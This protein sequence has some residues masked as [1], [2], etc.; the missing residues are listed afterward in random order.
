[1]TQ[2]ANIHSDR[3]L[4]CCTRYSRSCICLY[5]NSIPKAIPDY[6]HHRRSYHHRTLSCLR[7]R[8]HM[9]RV[10][11]SASCSSSY[12]NMGE[13]ERYLGTKTYHTSS[14]LSLLRRL[15]Y[16]CNQHQHSNVTGRK[17]H[18]RNRWRRIDHLSQ[19]LHQ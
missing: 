6:R 1:M 14:K 9:D 2:A 12:T 19:H 3:R 16:I 8:L 4:P 15:S 13:I 11:I 10:R 18:T 5:M 7:R 17:S